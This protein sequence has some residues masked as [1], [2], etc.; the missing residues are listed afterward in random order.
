MN[1]EY[2][3]DWA[4]GYYSQFEHELREGYLTVKDLYKL[5]KER[6]ITEYQFKN[7]MEYLKGE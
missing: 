3:M 2:L 7:G 5:F 6:K 4:C 1:G